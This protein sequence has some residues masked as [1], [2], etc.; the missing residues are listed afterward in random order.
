[1]AAAFGWRS[2]SLAIAEL[3]DP[4]PPS[5]DRSSGNPVLR[6]LD[7]DG[8]SVLLCAFLSASG[9][10]GDNALWVDRAVSMCRGAAAVLPDGLVHLLASDVRERFALKALTE[11]F[12]EL[13]DGVS[14]CILEGYFKSLPGF[15]FD[16]SNQNSVALEQHGYLLMQLSR[17]FELLEFGE[18]VNPKLPEGHPL[19]PFGTRA[20]R[21][22]SY[23]PQKNRISQQVVSRQDELRR[24]SSCR[25]PNHAQ[26]HRRRRHA[27][28]QKPAKRRRSRPVSFRRQMKNESQRVQCCGDD[29]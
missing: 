5:F 17:V 16:E 13:P 29:P 12:L 24:R 1:M 9:Y 7:R 6:R 22:L 21:S 19:R 4:A 26:R 18:T 27:R 3:R 14:R 11:A 10:G 15:R 28:R 8:V 20:P 23:V 2:F 25:R